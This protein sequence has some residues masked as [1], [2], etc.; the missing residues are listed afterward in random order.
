MELTNLYGNPNYTEQQSTLAALLQQ[1]CSEK[2]LQP[3]SG[4]VPGQPS[5]DA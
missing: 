4:T 1:Q 3:S 5:W 2:R